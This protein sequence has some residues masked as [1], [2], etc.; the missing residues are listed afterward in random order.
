MLKHTPEVPTR[1]FNQMRSPNSPRK[2]H[3]SAP[4]SPSA[5]EEPAQ[6]PTKKPAKAQAKI[7]VELPA[8]PL[9]KFFP[10]SSHARP[11]I[12]QDNA[13]PVGS[14]HEQMNLVSLA[15]LI[16]FNIQRNGYWEWF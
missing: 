12:A 4:Q 1:V 16:D 3:Q 10:S 11:Y 6:R 15:P 2:V 14:S 8:N 7:L 5:T 13:I 9:P